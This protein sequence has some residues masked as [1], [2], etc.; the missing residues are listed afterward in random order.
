MPI[1]TVPPDADIEDVETPE[2]TV[3]TI[4][5]QT[6]KANNTTTFTILPRYYS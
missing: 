2:G 1:R 6:N 4:A 5:I 3:A